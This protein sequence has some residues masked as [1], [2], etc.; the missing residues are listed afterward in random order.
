[1]TNV[2]RARA[3]VAKMPSAIQGQHGSDAAFMVAKILIHDF[4]LS[5]NEAWPILLEYNERCDPPWSHSELKHKIESA[6]N[7]TRAKRE[8]GALANSRP[9][10]TAYCPIPGRKP[11]GTPG[12]TPRIL[13]QISIE[14][15]EQR[16]PA[17]TRTPD[18]QPEQTVTEDLTG[19][20]PAEPLKKPSVANPESI[21]ASRI[22]GE[23]RKLRDAG[24]LKGADDPEAAFY[25]SLIRDFGATFLPKGTREA[26]VSVTDNAPTRWSAKMLTG[27]SQPRREEHTDFLMAAFDPKD[28]FDFSNPDHVAEYKKLHQPIKKR[29]GRGGLGQGEGPN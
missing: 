12:G 20:A 26:T 11:M 17:V 16:K 4:A 18:P 5:E 13:G 28:V 19:H 9:H 24:A 15:F 1:M 6:K 8:R 2:D 21:E 14:M 27:Y 25:A 10:F 23:L 22:V 3:Y 29:P 7:L